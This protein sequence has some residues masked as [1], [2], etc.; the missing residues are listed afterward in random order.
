[1]TKVEYLFTDNTFSHD[2][3]PCDHHFY[4]P[5]LNTSHVGVKTT[6]AYNMFVFIAEICVSRRKNMFFG[7]QFKQ[8][9]N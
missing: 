3:A 4:H 1:M 8:I 2:T 9:Q 5:I 6:I 7:K